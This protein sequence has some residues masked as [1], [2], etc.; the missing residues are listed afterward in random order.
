MGIIANVNGSL[1]Q[2]PG[3]GMSGQPFNCQRKDYRSFDSMMKK[4][5]VKSG[6]YSGVRRKYLSDVDVPEAFFLP[7]M[8]NEDYCIFYISCLGKN[9]FI[10]L[11]P[12]FHEF[13]GYPNEQFKKGAMDFWFSL[14]NPEDMESVST[15]I[16]ASHKEL[17][18]PPTDSAIPEPL[19][20][21]YRFKHADGHWVH[22]RDTRY[23]VNYNE[24]KVI[25]KV[26]CRFESI[27]VECATGDGL[28]DLLK[29]DKSCTKLLETALI[30]QDA[31]NKLPLEMNATL[32]D[33]PPPFFEGLTRR[34]KEILG[35]IA[36]GFSTKMIAEKCHISI[37]TVESHRKHL[38]VKLNVKNSMELV[39]KASKVFRF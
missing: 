31:K 2:T 9:R 33:S 8:E 32:P 4:P 34:E 3:I 24:N 7:V 22:I 23:L 11:D 1:I 10:Y 36:E 6:R 19:V 13:S 5:A 21:R 37:Y 25:D 12:Y 20:L 28:E 15:A 26:L 38:L 16:I 29:K 39:S 14:I 17:L 27:P 30:F 18:N 35:L